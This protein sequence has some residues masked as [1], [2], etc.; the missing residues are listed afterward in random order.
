MNL[1]PCIIFG[2][3]CTS[4]LVNAPER[5]SKGCW[6]VVWVPVTHAIVC[7][8]SHMLRN[9]QAIRLPLTFGKSVKAHAQ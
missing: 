7:P 2:C 8:R 3:F 5:L 6:Q 4:C 1:L 9:S